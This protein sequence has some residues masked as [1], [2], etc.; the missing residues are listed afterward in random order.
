MTVIVVILVLWNVG[1][2][3]L[4]LGL[5]RH[6]G[7][8]A[9]RMNVVPA[10]R[11]TERLLLQR[12]IPERALRTVQQAGAWPDDGDERYVVWFSADCT[13]CMAA[14]ASFREK[15]HD[16]RVRAVSR[17]TVA[18]ISGNSGVAEAMATDLE[19]AGC[20]VIRDPKARDVAEAINLPGTPI[21]LAVKDGL[22]NGWTNLDDVDRLVNFRRANAQR[23]RHLAV[24]EEVSVAE[25]S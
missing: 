15:G 20:P 9:V 22:V 17:R 3:A 7:I 12:P 21:A 8:M 25:D 24:S 16:D 6:V 10:T 4:L 11:R 1:L 14:S 18:L 2:S 23:A 19:E 5:A 13:M